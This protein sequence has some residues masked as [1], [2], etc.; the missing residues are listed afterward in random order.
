MLPDI[1][2]PRFYRG[3]IEPPEIPDGCYGVRLGDLIEND[4]I[5]AWDGYGS[6][7]SQVKGGSIPYIRV[8]DI[9]NWELYRNPVTGIPEDVYGRIL[10]TVKEPEEGDVIFVRRGSYR[11]ETV[12]MA[13]PRDRRVLPTRELLTF[14]IRDGGMNTASPR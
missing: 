2:V 6:P 11:I 7:E 10:A 5:E 4:T 12:A 13:S 14:R 8:S 9:V 1:L 3:Q